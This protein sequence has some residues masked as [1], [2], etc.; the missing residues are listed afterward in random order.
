MDRTTTI[1]VVLAII[2]VAIAAF[3]FLREPA[4]VDTAMQQT[5]TTTV[6]TMD[7]AG[8]RAEAVADLTAL[9]V[10]AEAGETYESL[11]SD[12]SRVRANLA[13][14]Y[15]DASG[16]AAEEWTQLQAGFDEFETSARAGTS[17]FLDSISNLIARFSA[18]VRT[19]T[20]TEWR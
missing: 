11:Q 8:A 18:D 14:A 12:F 7:R 4:A 16:E 6:Q 20:T 17:S 9:K 10:R 2:A 3:Y 13:L 19:E 15:E 1:W 5:A